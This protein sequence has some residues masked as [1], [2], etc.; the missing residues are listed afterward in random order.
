[1]S[2]P[3]PPPSFRTPSPG[4]PPARR[5]KPSAPRIH[6]PA[7]V[8]SES[9]VASAALLE[10]FPDILAEFFPMSGADKRQLPYNVALLSETLT[11]RR[12]QLAE[13]SYW[14]SPAL[15]GAYLWYFLP[16]NLV[17]LAAL[18]PG[19][20]FDLEPDA[21]ILDLGS[22]PLVLPLALWLS[23]PDL[24]EL[25]LHFTCLDS[26]ALPLR[27]GG[28]LFRALAGS[29]SPWR[30]KTVAEPMFRA[31]PKQDRYFSLLTACN[32]LNEL[33]PERHT[34]LATHLGRQVEELSRHLTPDGRL[35]IVEPGNR[36]GGK[37]I[38]MARAAALQRDFTAM[39][40]CPHQEVCPLSAQGQGAGAH[41]HSA[42][43]AHAPTSWCHFALPKKEAAVPAWLDKL[44]QDA[45]LAKDRLT[46]SWLLLKKNKTSAR[47][48]RGEAEAKAML[49]ANHGVQAMAGRVVS[50]ALTLPGKQGYFF[51]V[52]SGRGLVLLQAGRLL[53]SGASVELLFTG[54]EERDPKSGAWLVSQI[55]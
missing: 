53:R 47:R 34:T 28:A 38:S 52:C 48:L 54:K 9:D 44:S 55:T 20:R 3:V 42:G 2:K 16:W 11:S 8:F 19:L 18:L 12:G 15:T 36:L 17:R 40:P 27:L 10:S 32:M 1:M 41:E 50:N 22:G 25:P 7:P 24:R 26:A 4:R 45:H 35:L 33:K 39:A 14:T 31:L 13:R 49:E 37:I 23:R 51:Y 21:K 43:Q 6:L 29:D 30:F 46:L 5:A